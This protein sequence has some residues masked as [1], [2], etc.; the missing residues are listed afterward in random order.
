MRTRETLE[1]TLNFAPRPESMIQNQKILA[2]LLLDIRE[3]FQ[4][5]KPVFDDIRNEIARKKAMRE[6]DVTDTNIKPL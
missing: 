6:F 3:M 2:E 1:R 4:D 5:Y